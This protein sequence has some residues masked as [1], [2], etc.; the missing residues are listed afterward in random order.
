MNTYILSNTNTDSIKYYLPSNLKFIG[1]CSYGNYL[2]DLIDKKS[3]LNKDNIELVIFLIDG[4]ELKITNDLEDIFT[5]VR[6]FLNER[7]CIFLLSTISLKPYFIDT[8]LNISNEF[9]FNTNSRIIDFCKE[10]RNL[11][12]L[13]IHKII[14]KFGTKNCVDNKF[15]YVGRIKYTS[16]F[17]KE[18]SK[19]VEG[20]LSAINTT[21]KKVL[22][23]DLDNTIWGGV[24]GEDGNNILI[25]VKAMEK[26]ILN[27]KKVSSI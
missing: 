12:V 23:L 18:V 1:S 27:S 17:F 9:E 25:S 24:V 8:Y 11:F 22:V 5:S 14:T 15:W 7:E 20:I 13:D 2:I 16:L 19:E 10:K 26:Y 3:I 4:D 6:N 21:S